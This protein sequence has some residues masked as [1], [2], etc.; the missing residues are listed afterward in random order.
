MH[1]TTEPVLAKVQWFDGLVRHGCEV[2][3]SDNVM[4]IYHKPCPCLASSFYLNLGWFFQWGLCAH[5][6]RSGAR[7]G[8]PS[9]MLTTTSV[10]E[11]SQDLP[12]DTTTTSSVGMCCLPL[13]FH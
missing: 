8:V 4:Y 2:H 6:A 1:S 3:G 13:L 11:T 5:A 7:V 10:W 12:F 9:L